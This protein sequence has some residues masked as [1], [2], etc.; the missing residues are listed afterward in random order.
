MAYR[1]R[2]L[3]FAVISLVM[4]MVEKLDFVHAIREFEIPTVCRGQNPVV[5][6][7]IAGVIG[8]QR[9]SEHSLGLKLNNADLE[10]IR[11]YCTLR[12]GNTTY[13][14]GEC[15]GGG[16]RSV[17]DLSNGTAHLA[18]VFSR[19]TMYANTY[20]SI[21]APIRYYSLG[22][23]SRNVAWR[24]SE[25]Q[26]LELEI[27]NDD[28]NQQCWMESNE[29]QRKALI[30]W[31]VQR[32]LR[33][34]AH[35][36]NRSL[37]HLEG[38]VLIRVD[39]Q[40]AVFGL[41]P[42]PFGKDFIYEACK[43][44]LLPIDVSL[45]N[46][47][48]L[49]YTFCSHW[50]DREKE[51]ELFFP[52]DLSTVFNF[53]FSLACCMAFYQ[54]WPWLGGRWFHHLSSYMRRTYPR[55]NKSTVNRFQARN[56]STVPGST[57]R[58]YK[59]NGRYP[60]ELSAGYL[61]Q[62]PDD[63]D[64]TMSHAQ[65]SPTIRRLKRIMRLP[66]GGGPVCYIIG[67]LLVV[68]ALGVLV[69]IWASLYFG[70]AYD[71]RAQLWSRCSKHQHS[72]YLSGACTMLVAMSMVLVAMCSINYYQPKPDSDNE[73]RMA[74]ATDTTSKETS[75]NNGR[76][77][78]ANAPTRTR[79][80][81]KWITVDGDCLKMAVSIF[82]MLVSPLVV[83]PF[84]ANLLL[85]I[86]F[87]LTGLVAYYHTSLLSALSIIKILLVD[88]VKIT[89]VNEA[90]CPGI[91]RCKRA[92]DTAARQLEEE[93]LAESS[94][95]LIEH[96]KVLGRKKMLTA[97]S[98][99]QQ[100]CQHRLHQFFVSL[101][102]FPDPLRPTVPTITASCV[103]RMNKC[104][105]KAFLT[106]C[107][108]SLLAENGYEYSL[109]CRE[110]SCD[111]DDGCG[112]E[113]GRLEARGNAVCQ[114][115]DSWYAKVRDQLHVRVVQRFTTYMY[116]TM[117]ACITWAAI[118]FTLELLLLHISKLTRFSNWTNFIIPA[119][120]LL[121]TLIQYIRKRRQLYL[122][123]KCE[124][125][126]EAKRI[127]L[128]LMTQASGSSSSDGSIPI[129]DVKHSKE[130]SA[131]GGRGDPTPHST[132]RETNESEENV[133]LSPGTKSA[134]NNE[135]STCTQVSACDEI[136][137]NSESN[138]TED[139][140][141]QEVHRQDLLSPTAA[142]MIHLGTSRANGVCKWISA[143]PSLCMSVHHPS[144]SVHV[145]P[146]TP[147]QLYSYRTVAEVTDSV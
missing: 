103:E 38:S 116:G 29:H 84:L 121:Q 124:M 139:G 9:D 97:D 32:T 34:L 18:Y 55:P 36:A 14:P 65:V 115:S 82:L 131:A 39:S 130:S 41:W 71:S 102:A 54:L 76:N 123:T 85:V 21:Q 90:V 67:L 92:C 8:T 93:L 3:K 52:R 112:E 145:P 1:V 142:E 94:H 73:L 119:L 2:I 72:F 68:L 105:T 43:R 125:V 23:L 117:A 81:A 17:D 114:R 110:A 58:E 6:V 136:S 118:L 50:A 51:K 49:N 140:I 33:D 113:C 147:G 70:Q 132:I 64:P 86:S 122:D 22:L 15:P 69:N 16:Q 104:L 19:D 120:I 20:L 24:A 108:S 98:R 61:L 135:E 111:E 60:R 101:F 30:H 87:T 109:V 106:L 80:L 48:S 75:C 28:E 62:F 144:V 74:S 12:I 100:M 47:S 78:G 35:L 27:A 44:S 95:A 126:V 138:L 79:P 13:A 59:R 66:Y 89:G 25:N 127:L 37:S 31:R 143:P 137:T 10:I 83:L 7:G 40:M 128:I 4:L 141:R 96:E 53:V 107:A 129:P 57:K 88:I 91:A 133:W 134:S 11:V 56:S 77:A 146:T 5:Y 46:I 45:E 63:R 42:F 99:H 26:T